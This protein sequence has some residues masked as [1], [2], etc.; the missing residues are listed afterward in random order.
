[1]RAP[2]EGI[3]VVDS[4]DGRGE[5]CG[6]LLADLGAEVI[7]VES[8]EG[9]TL[10]HTGP[11]DPTGRHSLAHAWRNANKRSVVADTATEAGRDRLDALL[12]QADVWIESSDPDGDIDPAAVAAAHPHLIVT[13][14]TAFGHTGPNRSMIADD[15]VLEAW[16]GFMFKAGLA[17]KPPLLPPTPMATDVASVTAAVATVLGLHQRRATGAGQHIDLAIQTAAA[18][19]TDWSYSNASVMREAGRPYNEV[20]AGGGFMYP[21]FA[22]RDGFVRMVILSPRQWQSLWQWMGEPPSSRTSS[23]PRSAIAS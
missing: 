10:R 11:F 15:D 23:G 1:M 22:C 12:A 21:I 19:A 16:A 3:R 14:I 4:T 13:S 7:L 8:P 2:L 18:A 5:L 20:R 9:S 6:R 17:P